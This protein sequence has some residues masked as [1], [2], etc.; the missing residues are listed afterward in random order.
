VLCLKNFFNVKK[1]QI[2]VAHTCNSSYSGG[3]GQEDYGSKPSSAN[4]STRPYLEN[5][6]TEKGW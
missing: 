4:L 2:L 6:F 3:R 1:S 5:P